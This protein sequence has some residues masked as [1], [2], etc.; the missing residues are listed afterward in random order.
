MKILLIISGSVAAYKS[1]ELIRRGREV[2]HEF[3]TVLT[4][5]G[6]QFITAMSAAS[7]S[8]NPC[9]TDLFSLKDESEMGH[10]RLSRECDLVMVAPA[11]ADLLA[12]MATGRAD[13]LASTL[14]LATDKPVVAAPAMNTKMWEHPATQ[15]NMQQLIADGI[16]MIQPNAGLLAC[17]EQGTGRMADVPEMLEFLNT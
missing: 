8:E 9:Y 5:G 17:G 11:S 13:D 7:L 14:L 2:G 16:Q 4:S 6:A 10:I 3:T 15:R 1:L 12:K